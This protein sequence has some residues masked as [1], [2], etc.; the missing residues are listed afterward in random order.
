M[1]HVA[2]PCGI[3]SSETGNQPLLAP[4][5]TACHHFAITWDVIERISERN[6]AQL[7]MDCEIEESPQPDRKNVQ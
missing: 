5:R 4:S 6:M 3:I 7:L 1:P 2:L